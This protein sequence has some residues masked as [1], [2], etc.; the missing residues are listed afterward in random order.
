MSEELRLNSTPDIFVSR[1]EASPLTDETRIE[2][3]K[4]FLQSPEKG[5]AFA[6]AARAA[7]DAQINRELPPQLTAQ[8]EIGRI[9]KN[10]EYFRGSGQAGLDGN[11]NK[12]FISMTPAPPQAAVETAQF[13]QWNEQLA[14]IPTQVNE[15][16][17]R[18]QELEREAAVRG[19]FD[20]WAKDFNR[21]GS[22]TGY[23][24]L[25]QPRR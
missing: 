12:M 18:A 25:A 2:L 17:L 8:E 3:K 4:S 10:L 24:E 6:I 1:T 22:D 16:E 11:N 9:G 21:T 5:R 14:Q 7:I 20:R 19:D 23:E 13:T 15:N